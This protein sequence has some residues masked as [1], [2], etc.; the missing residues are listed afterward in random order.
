MF[1]WLFGNNDSNII[2]EI[3]EEAVE[4]TPEEIPEP[5]PIKEMLP[6]EVIGRYVIDVVKNEKEEYQ[7][8]YNP[9]YIEL[10]YDAVVNLLDEVI[11]LNNKII[12]FGISHRRHGYILDYEIYAY[13]ELATLLES[14]DGRDSLM[15][16]IKDNISHHIKQHIKESDIAKYK[17]M[18]KDK[19]SF[20]IKLSF[21]IER[22]DRPK[23]VE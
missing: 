5:E 11:H 17:K 4:P 18:V 13:Q 10:K 19:H 23:G 15:D 7:H 20:D 8:Y 6:V 16:S 2:D 9:Y 21:E 12:T 22:P 14:E 3:K 1:K